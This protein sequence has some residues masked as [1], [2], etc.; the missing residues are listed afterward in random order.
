MTTGAPWLC[1]YYAVQNGIVSIAVPIDKLSIVVSI[2]FS[3]LVFHEKLSKR[4]LFGL[5]LMIAGTLVM[6]LFA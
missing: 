2:M 1:Y 4:A 5:L 3:Y 6:A